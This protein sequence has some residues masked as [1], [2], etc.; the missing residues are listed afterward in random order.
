VKEKMSREKAYY[1]G[2]RV[3]HESSLLGKKDKHRGREEEKNRERENRRG[4]G[5]I[6]S[7]REKVARRA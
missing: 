4:S 5:T 2:E 3:D 7:R 1:N 6:A